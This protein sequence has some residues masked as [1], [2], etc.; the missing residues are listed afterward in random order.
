MT[1]ET[2]ETTKTIKT[3]TKDDAERIVD[4][5]VLAFSTDPAMR[6]MYPNSHQYLTYFPKLVRTFAG[7][8]FE[9]GTA[10]SVDNQA[11]AALWF[12]P[13]VGIDEEP[14]IAFFEQTICQADRAELFA[15]FEQMGNYHPNE[16][17]WYL[18]LLG[19]DPTQQGKGYG[20]ALMQ[21][22]LREC[23]RHHQ[24]AYLESSNAAT[25]SFYEQ[26]GF[27]LLGIIQE[28]ASLSIFPMLRYPNKTII[29]KRS[30]P[31]SYCTHLS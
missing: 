27:E 24:L 4:A 29:M 5:L 21:H 30:N 3:V 16:P 9:C 13:G 2:I 17:H 28:G 22:T 19:V 15:V 20:S 14:L 18:A 12:P 31:I 7:K 10:Y 25:I 1:N 8:A 23:D 26:H 11:G 6:W